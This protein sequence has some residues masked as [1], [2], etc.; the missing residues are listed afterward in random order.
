[1][2]LV[3]V[4]LLLHTVNDHEVLINTDMITSMVAKG[5]TYEGHF[6][7]GVNC[8]VNLADGKFVTVVE[9][10]DEIRVFVG[11]R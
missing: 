11:G 1:M 7:E 10:C 4:L 3:A 5:E 8:Q 9:T 6:V 2:K